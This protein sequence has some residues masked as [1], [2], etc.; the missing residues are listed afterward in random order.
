MARTLQLNQHVL[1]RP[2]PLLN[3]RWI[4][5]TVP[6]GE[7]T[8]AAGRGFKV[9]PEYVETFE[10]TFNNVKVDGVFFGGG[11]NYFPGFHDVSAFN[12]TFYGDSGGNVLR[13]LNHWKSQV[14]DFNT[15]LYNLPPAYKRDWVII[16][17]D[18]QGNDV[19]SY[20]CSGS[21]PADTGQ[22]T[23]DYNDGN[24][25]ISLNQNFS[26]DNVAPLGSGSG[27]GSGGGGVGVNYGSADAFGAIA[28]VVGAVS[29]IAGM[30]GDEGSE[31][32]SG[33]DSGGLD[34]I[35]EP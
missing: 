9:G 23:L 7:G 29:A 27:V 18:A 22:L 8:D 13:W 3:F 2:D 4:V 5:E 32:G 12:I 25:R 24:G 19:A 35:P 33:F 16:L 15:G 17:L 31:G 11:Y 20:Q 6:F 28:G 21:W 34:F 14:K 10:L 30:F 1:N 26:V